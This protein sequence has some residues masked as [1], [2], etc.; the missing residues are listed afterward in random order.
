MLTDSVPGQLD[1]IP[2]QR[3]NDILNRVPLDGIGVKNNDAALAPVQITASGT[4]NEPG[5][6]RDA[7]IRSVEDEV[8]D[9]RSCAVELLQAER[10][11]TVPDGTLEGM[12]VQEAH[13]TW[14]ATER[15]H[16]R[17]RR[18]FERSQNYSFDKVPRLQP[19][20]RP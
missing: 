6:A 4:P 18:L 13:I 17:V 12:D 7:R 11:E 3:K 14:Q 16:E 1:V 2:W 20:K 10:S 5:R 19:F 15:V 9:N 8:A